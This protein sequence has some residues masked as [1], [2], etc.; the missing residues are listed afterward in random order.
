VERQRADCLELADRLGWTVVET[1][2]G[3]DL[4]QVWANCT[5]DIKG[6]IVDALMTVTILPAPRGRR[7]GGGYFDPAFVR[8]EW[9]TV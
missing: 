6:K 4:K 7:P 9:K 3:D 1:Y 8:V 5:P 2:T